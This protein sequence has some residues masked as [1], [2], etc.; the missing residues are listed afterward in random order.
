M[1]LQTLKR[2]AAVLA[3]VGLGLTSTAFAQTRLSGAG[4]TFPYPFYERLVNAY[5]QEK[6]NVAVD[7]QPIGS[8]GGIKAITD[9][10]VDFA[11]SDAP[12]NDKEI[13]GAGGEENLIMFPSTA[14]G[15]VPIYNLPGVQGDLKMTGELL[16]DIYLGTV[17]MWNDPK[18]KALNPGVN[19]PATPI[20]PAWRTDGSG[21]TFVFTNYLAT[22]S[23]EFKSLIGTGK[24]VTWPFGQGG[25]GND[26]VAAVVSQT[27]G[28]LGYVEQAYAQKNNISFAAMKNKSGKFVK[29]TPESVSA[30]G[31]GAVGDMKGNLLTAD[32]WDQK[33]DEA[34]P[35][36][37]FTYLI[38]YK[39]LSNLKSKE[40]AQSLVDFLWWA[41]HDGQKFAKELD[42]AP[43]AKP[44][45][46]K[47][48]KA[49]KE[50]T[51][52]GEKLK[53]GMGGM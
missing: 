50:L 22:Q 40:Q 18:V 6:S 9:K 33:G 23:S 47:V 17:S 28:T 15:V 19:L 35:I 13:K 5:G 36:S 52:K 12:M 24:Q 53:V 1:L 21:T 48:E 34:Y 39:D 4:A 8:G 41:T 2:S 10:T 11:G 49:M 20:T 45:Q 29:A 3:V 27:P 51:Y 38:V 14:G 44:V 42:Y 26:G 16:A 25:K 32:I 43:L 37:T 7:Y 46:E 31:A 30:A